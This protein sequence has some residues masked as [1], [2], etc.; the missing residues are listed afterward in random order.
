MHQ[1]QAICAFLARLDS[2]LLYLFLSFS[3]SINFA[4]HSPLGAGKNTTH[5]QE[6]SPSSCNSPLTLTLYLNFHLTTSWKALKTDRY[7]SP[8]TIG[9]P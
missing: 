2:F 6:L 9:H 3:L 8:S 4:P 1:G 5:H 7:P